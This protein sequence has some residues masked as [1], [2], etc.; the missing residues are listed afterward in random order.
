MSH[1]LTPSQTVGPYLHIGLD[2]LNIRDLAPP[3]IEGERITI[4][5]RLL[6]ADGREAGEITS[7]S[8]LAESGVHTA[9]GYIKRGVDRVF[10]GGQPL[11]FSN[12]PAP[13][14]A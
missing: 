3:S 5:G 9:L 10:L 4:H 1:P 7:I 6:D 12:K 2:W 14:P 8:P 13:T 11:D